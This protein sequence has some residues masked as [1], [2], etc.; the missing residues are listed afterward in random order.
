[1]RAMA[2]TLALFSHVMLATGGWALLEALSPALYSTTRFATRT[3]TPLFIL[4][5]GA[6]VELAY[7]RFWRR[8]RRYGARR[9]LT[10]SL[11]CFA[12]LVL[13]GVAAVVGGI[14]SLRDLIRGIAFIGGIMNAEIYVFYVVFF[15][16]AV[17]LVAL[18]VRFGIP[19]ALAAA[20]SWWILAE[21]I[22][23][24][25]DD[26]LRYL[27]SRLF[28][29]GDLYG[30]SPF[31]ALILAVIGMALADA[32]RNSERRTWLHRW[33]LFA[34]CLAVAVAVAVGLLAQQGAADVVR[35]Y[36]T[37]SEYRSSNHPGYY[38]IGLI[39][40]ML[41]LTVASVL[42]TRAFH[43]RPFR[44]GPFSGDSLIAFTAGNVIINLLYRTLPAPN[45]AV[46]LA[47]AMIVIGG[48]WLIVYG[49]RRLRPRRRTEPGSPVGPVS[50]DSAQRR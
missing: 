46:A 13:I 11:K 2:I 17:P 1:M 35:S 41:V 49:Y 24:P 48:V 37:I 32:L 9:L 45:L 22:P 33:G 36:I 26:R 4:L 25:A 28:G 10:Q 31:H 7:V 16:I 39:G 44:P 34:G 40:A 8:D 29:I 18:R 15:V 38:A 21:L 23:A 42:W 3:A 43:R 47:W 50:R 19:A 12:C 27:T 30:P 6:A 5:A 14:M 20:A